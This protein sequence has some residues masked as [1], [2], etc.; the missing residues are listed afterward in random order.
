MSLDLERSHFK[1]TDKGNDYT[2]QRSYSEVIL[3]TGASV[4]LAPKT[5]TT[6]IRLL[7]QL[8]TDSMVKDRIGNKFVVAVC[9]FLFLMLNIISINY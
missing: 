2:G 4:Q 6:D 9:I 5:G 3:E 7:D 8:N 1:V